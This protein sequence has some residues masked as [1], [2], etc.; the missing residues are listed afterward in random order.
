MYKMLCHIYRYKTIVKIFAAFI[1][2]WE[3]Q[4]HITC[5]QF[6]FSS[7]GSNNTILFLVG[8][9]TKSKSMFMWMKK[10]FCSILN[11]ITSL[12]VPK[13]FPLLPLIPKYLRFFSLFFDDFWFDSKWNKITCLL[14]IVKAK[15]NRKMFREF[16]FS[17][18]IPINSK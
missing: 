16:F 11:P 6:I 3:T 10:H 7:L 5:R 15:Q 2:S 9:G 4:E 8:R 13:K 1:M 14:F 17:L 12:V 18:D